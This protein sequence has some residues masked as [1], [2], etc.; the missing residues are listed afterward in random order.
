MSSALGAASRIP[1]RGSRFV[2]I[3]DF[4]AI[5]N[6]QN[7][8]VALANA[9]AIQAAI[10]SLGSTGGS[11]YVPTG[12][13]YVRRPI[14]LDQNSVTL[15][16]EGMTSSRLAG[17]SPYGHDVVIM[18]V[19]RSPSGVNLTQDNFVDLYGIL[20]APAA[21]SPG[22][23]WGYRTK[24]A[25]LVTMGGIL[26]SGGGGY[27]TNVTKLTVDFAIDLRV[28]SLPSEAGA[29]LGMGQP[30]KG[31]SSPWKVLLKSNN[32]TNP[33]IRV[34]FNTSDGGI[35]T[36]VERAFEFSLG[37]IALHRC[38]FQIDLDNAQVMAYVDGV[39]VP[40]TNLL[41]SGFSPGLKFYSNQNSP[42]G[43]GSFD[44]QSVAS[45]NWY[46]SF[47]DTL[48]CG[49]KICQDLL[50]A[51]NGPG[52]PQA[53][54]DGRSLNDAVRYFSMEPSVIGMLPMTESPSTVIR[55]RVVTVWGPGYA[56][57]TALF[58]DNTLHATWNY[59]TSYSMIRNLS[60]V[61][62]I[63]FG[64]AL[65][66]GSLISCAI[67]GVDAR[68]GL[69][70]IGSKNTV[71]SYDN[72]ITSCRVY[73]LDAAFYQFAMSTTFVRDLSV[74]GYVRTAFR[75]DNCDL[76]FHG[77]RAPAG[78]DSTDYFVKST[79]GT[80][81]ME[82]TSADFEGGPA[83]QI[84]AFYFSNP[85]TPMSCS[86]LE[87]IG[88]GTFGWDK[89]FVILHQATAEG[90]NGTGRADFRMN[91]WSVYEQDYAS[92]VQVDGPVWHGEFTGS[93]N[94]Q[95]PKWIND[96]SGGNCNIVS[97]HSN[98]TGPPRDGIW[99]TGLHILNVKRPACSQFAEWRC[100]NGGG[101]GTATPP[102]WFGVQR[103]DFD[104]SAVAT[105]LLGHSYW[106]AGASGADRLGFWTDYV[107]NAVLNRLFQGTPFSSPTNLY[108]GLSCLR[109]RRNGQIQEIPS[110]LNGVA[111]GYARVPI[112][113]SSATNGSTSNTAAVAFPQA[114]AVWKTNQ[115]IKSLFIADA[116]T[117]GNVL[118]MIDLDYQTVAAGSTLTF[119]PGQIALA[120]APLSTCGFAPS[121][122]NSVI[123][124]WLGGAAFPS[125]TVYLA[126]STGPADP[127]NAPVE[128]VG[129]GYA[130]IATSATNWSASSTSVPPADI[131]TLGN[132]GRL[133]FPAPTSG[134]GTVR[135]V[136]LMD[137]VS[138]GNVI[139]A[140]NLTAPL[141]IGAGD[142]A[143]KFTPKAFWIS[144]A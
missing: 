144:M 116:A 91:S 79:R 142:P 77:V 105:Y 67:E 103:I 82:D 53:R 23:K 139:A 87:N 29:L 90:Y 66:T 140:A 32:G 114:T 63:N 44:I 36:G 138:G 84:S 33:S 2:D 17:Y 5:A 58:L 39:Q 110:T 88:V 119:A 37:S 28:G 78:T 50:Y 59:P 143:V 136:Y 125:P 118:A 45:S 6:V 26:D 61:C 52:A 96:Q 43:I 55:D 73:G 21:R 72:R 12:T 16:G 85:T 38:S 41:G 121:V 34:S 97:R 46:G 22:M 89:P 101:Y 75:L 106:T 60:L 71:G 19:A 4:G 11:V 98:F 104:S 86:V 95:R 3:R 123:N 122:D 69:H 74:N 130:R 107:L 131:C 24:G 15:C 126:L 49:L 137:S 10:D 56:Q 48:F 13:F 99:S 135:S 51:N 93:V 83:P 76:N 14:F 113:F 115:P 128:P 62:G 117:G 9:Y 133:S 64:Q 30:S 1:D 20:D 134:W 129:G 68:G 102:S 8:A 111:T 47:F 40:F 141:T 109:A 35:D 120:R 70:G 7:D 92:I 112:Q 127:T 108:V 65:S 57:G 31:Y 100:A 132:T 81:T 25:H 94:F 124:A 42:F 54:L 27:W 80:V 18:G